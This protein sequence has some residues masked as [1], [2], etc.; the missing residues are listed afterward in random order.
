MSAA[1]AVDPLFSL[2]GRRV[3][4]AGHRGLVGKALVRRLEREGCELQTVDRAAVDLRRQQ[5]TEDWV[6]GRRPE[7]IFLAAAKVGGIAANQRSPGDFLYD[8][9]AIQTNVLEA[10]RRAGVA[11][12]ISLGS[13]CVY[14]RLAQQ[15]MA[16]QEL[17]TGPLEP[18]NQ[19]YA[20]AKIAGL[21]LGQAL[22]QQH[23]LDVITVLPTNLYG[24]GDHFELE[25]SHVVPAMIR[26][27]H[28]AKLAGAAETPLWGTGSPRREFL[29]VDDCA[30]GLIFL[31][32]RYSSDEHIN[33]GVGSDVSIRE[34]AELVARAVGYE[35]RFVYDTSRPDGPPRKLLDVSRL[36]ALGWRPKIELEAGLRETYRWFVEHVA[37]AR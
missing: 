21:R 11:K 23:G 35:G 17:L 37:A 3:W 1:P 27:V 34:L 24:P 20:V 22:R 13:S 8:N 29:H 15:P 32:Q 12:V 9:L 4:V 7:V 26:K 14:P 18:T 30:D 31:A 2:R 28:E 25:S 19:W 16:E 10:A 33:L 6:A 5:P 36:T